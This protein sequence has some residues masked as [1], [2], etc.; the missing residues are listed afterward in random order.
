M[1]KTDRLFS[2]MRLARVLPHIGPFLEGQHWDMKS[3]AGE[4][5]SNHKLIA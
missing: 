4:A 5:S 1:L 2:V 3:W